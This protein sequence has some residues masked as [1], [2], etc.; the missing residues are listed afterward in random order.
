MKFKNPMILKMVAMVTSFLAIDSLP[1]VDG[2]VQFSE[3]QQNKLQAELSQQS[4]DDLLKALNS[5]IEANAEVRNFKAQIKELLKEHG[6][7]PEAVQAAADA[8][9]G[10]DGPQLSAEYVQIKG[11]MDSLR[12]TIDQLVNA[13]VPD[14]P[15]AKIKDAI[16]AKIKHNTTHLFA[17]NKEYDA[18]EGRPWNAA[19]AGLKV[20]AADYSDAV[21]IQKL[22]GDAQLFYRENPTELQ[23]LHRDN[24]GLPS[25]WPKRLKVDSVVVSGT[26]LTAEITQSRKFGWLPKNNQII[27]AEEGRIFPVQIDAQWSGARLQEI[28]SSWLNFLNKE[29]SQPEKWSFVRFL[30]TELMKQARVEDRISTINGIYVKTPEDAQVAGKMINRQ[31]GLLYQIWRAREITKKYRPFNVGAPTTANI[32]DYLHDQNT[33]IIELLPFDVKNAPNLKL[34]M[35][36]KWWDAY[37]GKY[38]EI[39]GQNMDYKGAPE[40]P[41]N[42]PNIEVVPLVDMT[43]TGFMFFT[44][45]DNIEILENVPAEKAAFKFQQILR[46]LHLMADYKLGV[47]LIH[48]GRKANAADPEQFKIQSIWSNNMP[49]F[50]NDVFIPAFDNKSG[51]LNFDYRNVQVAPDWDTDITNL[52][53]VVEGQV[54]KIKGDTTLVNARNVKDNANFDIQGD[55]NLKSGGTLTLRVNENLKA[56]E[57]HRTAGPEQAPELLPV[58]FED[59]VIDAS[60][61]N[62]F[63]YTGTADLTITE[64]V[65]G[66]EGQTIKVYGNNE[67][68]MDLTFHTSG[69]INVGADAVLS[70]AAHY[71]ALTLDNG[72]WYKVKLVNA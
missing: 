36:K 39:N 6:T 65:G 40:H 12:A 71:I 52:T 27:E 24:F 29:G 15:V 22:N 8:A 42:Y 3:D 18:F 26:V 23:S 58:G 54:I 19:A 51:E 13:P 61:G 34:Y 69:N 30:V 72:V 57:M 7:T 66:Y 35:E 68:N 41:E 33:G 28:E 5:E 16:N 70:D 38:K 43:G 49:I 64:I 25:F 56:V 50:K 2:K 31:N 48:I 60:E 32:Y 46:D 14:S 11:A 10:G 59:T 44:F 17:S 63:A 20:S 1:I 9:E 4:L 45:G 21:T 47:R 53:G 55:F 62:V 37:K 67:P